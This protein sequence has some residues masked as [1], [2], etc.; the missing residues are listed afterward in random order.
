MSRN[1]RFGS[2][3]LLCAESPCLH[4]F[5]SILIKSFGFSTLDSLIYN[6]PGGAILFVAVLFFLW[7]GDRIKRRILCGILPLMIGL[8]GVLLCWQLP[9]NLKVG[10]LIGY[11][12]WVH[13]R[14]S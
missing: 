8:L 5:F 11:Y 2:I 9:T 6:A 7:L 1:G 13:F 14:L 10:R 3:P 12:L 4:S